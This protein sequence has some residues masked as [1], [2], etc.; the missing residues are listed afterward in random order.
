SSGPL[1]LREPLLDA[2]IALE[3]LQLLQLRGIGGHGCGEAGYASLARHHAVESGAR[4]VHAGAR[5]ALGAGLRAGRRMRRAR[6][7]EL[8]QRL[9]HL[10]L[11]REQRG[12]VALELLAP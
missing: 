5:A 3:V 8:L 7:K 10:A 4:I 12:D 2:V 6:G 1:Q 11:L 9:L